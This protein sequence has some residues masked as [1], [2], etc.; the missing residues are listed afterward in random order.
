MPFCGPKCSLCCTIVSI[1]GIVQLVLMGVFFYTHSVALAEDL[2]LKEHYNNLDEFYKDVN[3]SYEQNAYNCWIAALIYLVTLCV[4]V[5][6]FW[7][8][9]RV[10]YQV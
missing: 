2:T 5:H 6:Q 7:L 10:S 4:S 8:N 3:A 9:N 1:W